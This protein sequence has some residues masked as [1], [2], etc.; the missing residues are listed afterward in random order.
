M[1]DVGRI[2]YEMRRGVF[3]DT[4]DEIFNIAQQRL[5]VVAER[6]NQY[7]QPGD[8]IRIKNRVNPQYLAGI[9]GEVIE[10]DKNVVVVEIHESCGPYRALQRLDIPT[11]L[12]ELVYR[13]T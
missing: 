1:S 8:D 5:K 12:V 7:L 3:D 11:T 13:G 6:I 9:T 4:I 2:M 10:V